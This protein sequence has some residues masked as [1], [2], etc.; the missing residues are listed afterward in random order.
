MSAA[1]EEIP[2]Q[3]PVRTL[4]TVHKN[5][6]SVVAVSQ[7]LQCGSVTGCS[8]QYEMYTDVPLCHM[9]QTLI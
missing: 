8:G 7:L 2:L 6:V 1:I 5:C 4:Q 9:T 3:F